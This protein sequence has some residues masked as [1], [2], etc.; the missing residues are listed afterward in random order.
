MQVDP[1]TL[2][3]LKDI[4]KN[5]NRPWFTE[6]KEKYE[7]ALGTI[8]DMVYNDILPAMQKKDMIEEAKIFRIY[9]DVRFSKD[10][11]PYKNNFGIGFTRATSRLRGGYYLHIEPG[12]G[13]FAGGGFWAPN[14]AD[15]KR[16]R[17]EFV[18]DSKTIVKIQSNKTFKSYFE[19]IQ[20]DALKTAPRGYDA[21]APLIDLIKKKQWIV[22]RKFTDEE[23]LE[24]KFSKEI[25]KTFEG[26]RPFFDYMSDVLTTD[27]NGESIL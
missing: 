22:M 3:F 16:I 4:T 23:L 9:K 14:P 11:T 5:N 8:K 19:S 24:P 17:D 26:M 27:L 10:K 18:Y 2:K 21:A 6:N 25:V 12:G 1:L 7:F 15:M 20:G 13:S